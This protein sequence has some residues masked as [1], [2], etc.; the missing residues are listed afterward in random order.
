MLVVNLWEHNKD[1]PDSR[2]RTWGGRAG[3]GISHV[4]CVLGGGTEKHGRSDLGMQL[5][6]KNGFLMYEDSTFHLQFQS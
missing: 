4:C 1:G 3:P 2:H 6:G 5:R